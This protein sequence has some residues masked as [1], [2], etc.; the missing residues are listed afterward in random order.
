LQPAAPHPSYHRQSGGRAA[1][2]GSLEPRHCPGCLRSTSEEGMLRRPLLS[3]LP[4]SG[5]GKRARATGTVPARKYL[6]GLLRA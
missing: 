3:F 4:A 1:E 5:K 6:N 2:L